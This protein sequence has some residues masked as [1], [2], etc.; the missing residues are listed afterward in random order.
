M[1]ERI[2]DELIGVFKQYKEPKFISN[3]EIVDFFRKEKMK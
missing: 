2:L 1:K 3:S